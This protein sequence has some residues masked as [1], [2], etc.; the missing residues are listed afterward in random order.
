MRIEQ[1]RP[2]ELSIVREIVQKTIV[3][4]YPA[5]YP[6]G[7][8]E[9]FRR[10]HSDEAIRADLEAGRVYLLWDEAGPAGTVTVHG[11]EMGRQF[12]LPDR[13]GRGLGRRLMDFAEARIAEGHDEIRLDASLPAK[14]IYL[15]RGY[16]SAEYHVLPVEGGQYL[17]YDVMR[18][19]A[20]MLFGE[21]EHNNDSH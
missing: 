10:H 11:D 1:A 4:I 13:Q 20:K 15:R 8:V 19:P 21:E 5:Y 17:C 3:T 18:K 9:F 16:V 14:A 6:A 7:A 12:V 2:E